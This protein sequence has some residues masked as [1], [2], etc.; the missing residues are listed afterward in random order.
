MD[1]RRTVLI[2]GCSSG[3]GLDM[4]RT[5]ASR[6]WRVLATCRRAEDAA[7]REAEGL[8]SFALDYADAGSVAAGA[9]E[10][11]ARAGRLDALVN[12]GA[13]AIPAPLEDVPREAM[14]AIFET[15]VIGWHDLTRRLLPALRDGRGR[16]V[17]VSSVLGMLSLRYRGAYSATKFAV[18]GWSDALRRELEGPETPAPGVRVVLVEP[19]P[20]R[21]AFRRNSLI[22][23]RRWAAIEGSAWGRAWAEKILPRLEAEESKT[24]A[25]FELG[26]EAVTRK[27]VRAL[28]SPRPR[29]RYYVTAP[30]YVAGVARGLPTRLQDLAFRGDH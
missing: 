12:N 10:A 18:E 24:S 28:E 20:I 4:A 14:R 30:T 8:E 3:I 26:P 27:V 29:A 16:V 17:N 21:S 25:R 9:A 5:L 7:A 22:A 13:F 23:T 11:L 1:D 2:T 6:G 15:N 19:G